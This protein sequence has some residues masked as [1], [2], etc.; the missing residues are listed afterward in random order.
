MLVFLMNKCFSWH[1]KREMGKLTEFPGHG[2]LSL[3]M[4][5]PSLAHE[6]VANSKS[7][8]NLRQVGFLGRVYHMIFNFRA[9][10]KPVEAF[11][12]LMGTRSNNLT[13]KDCWIS[14][15]RCGITCTALH[16]GTYRRLRSL[17]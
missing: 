12:L 9:V 8:R 6:T 14:N 1:G 5:F 3:E 2:K 11:S 7:H 4:F 10:I 16:P 13:T 17:L 15:R